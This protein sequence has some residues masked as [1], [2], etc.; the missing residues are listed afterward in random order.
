MVKKTLL[1]LI[2]FMSLIIFISTLHGQGSKKTITLPSGEVVCDLNGEW[3]AFVENYGPLAFAGSFPQIEKITQT[4]SSF[5]AIRMIDDPYNF[6][7][8][9]S[10][11]GELDKSGIKKVTIL[12]LAGLMEAKG[13][14]S[15]DGNKIVIDDGMCLRRT[16]TRK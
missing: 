6:K 11:Q 15:D 7:G 8:S 3:D 14:I 10:L 12:S 4:G 9:Q 13:Q 1:V 2:C 5:V 16:L